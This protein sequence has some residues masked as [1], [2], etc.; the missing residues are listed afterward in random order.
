MSEWT[1]EL[2]A[3]RNARVFGVAPEGIEMP[4]AD[5]GKAVA[6][7]ECKGE[8]YPYRS[9]TEVAYATYLDLLK[10][11]GEIVDWAYEPEIWKL[12]HRCTYCPDFCVTLVSADIQWHEIKGRKGA[13]FWCEPDAWIKI[14]VAAALFP[15]RK[16]YVVWPGDHGDWQK[17]RVVS[18]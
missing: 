2:I 3:A 14:K 15:D 17:E 16:I 1:E 18:A 11:T 12:A 10:K 5:V 13:R 7:P 4:I 9:K 8:W 6:T